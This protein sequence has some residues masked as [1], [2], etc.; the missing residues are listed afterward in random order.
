MAILET[1]GKFI[2][3]STIVIK[4]MVLGVETQDSGVCQARVL[5][6]IYTPYSRYFEIGSCY[7]AT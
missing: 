7:I 3:G 1:S 6:L 5:L 4:K 2:L